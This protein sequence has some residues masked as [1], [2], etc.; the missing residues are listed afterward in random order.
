M[1]KGKRGGSG[2]RVGKGEEKEGEGGV[3]EEGGKT[4]QTQSKH[5]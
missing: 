5:S 3:E 4:Y 2:G 1:F